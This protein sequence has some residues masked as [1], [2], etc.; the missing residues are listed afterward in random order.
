MYWRL[1]STDP[2]AAK[3]VVLAEKPVIADSASSLEP[4]LLDTLLLNLGTLSSVYHKPPE[5]QIPFL[6]FDSCN[7]VCRVCQIVKFCRQ[8]APRCFS[9]VGF[10]GL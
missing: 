8:I 3:A 9:F 4:S 6:R 7:G 10:I 1:L 5:V 2:D